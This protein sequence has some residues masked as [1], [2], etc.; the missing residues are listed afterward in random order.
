MSKKQALV[1]G[2]VATLA[3]AAAARGYIARGIQV[4]N[5]SYSTWQ[6]N[7]MSAKLES[8]SPT[9]KAVHESLYISEV[10]AIKQGNLHE[11]RIYIQIT[12]DIAAACKRLET[13]E[14]IGRQTMDVLYRLTAVDTSNVD[15]WPA[16]EG[17]KR[18]HDSGIDLIV[19]STQSEQ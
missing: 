2:S 8:I 4:L 3:A 16:R 9:F 5:L 6:S 11:A 18:A 15:Y 7:V 10:E 13:E 12:F 14:A 19:S 17:I 1:V